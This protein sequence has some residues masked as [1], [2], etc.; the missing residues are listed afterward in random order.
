MTSTSTPYLR[1]ATHPAGPDHRGGHRK[2]RFVIGAALVAV[3]ALVAA[4]V[5]AF[6]SVF[7]VRTVD[8]NGAAG[9]SVASIR[10]AAHVS[11]G[12]PLVRLDTAAIAA[13]VEK[14]PAIA[15]AKVSTSFPSTVTIT[16]TERTPVGYTREGE[17]VVLIDRDG[18][19]YRSVSGVPPH[20]PHFVLPAGAGGRETG[21]ALA[22]V[23]AALPAS[24][25]AEVVTVQAPDPTAITLSVQGGIEVRWGD[26]THSAEKAR[27]VR[28]LMA[29]HPSLID[30][31]DPA[32]PFTR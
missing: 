15:S 31:T 27:I 23:A 29:K 7:G 11:Q 6:S 30:V 4:W 8:V 18:V 32:Q 13:R 3:I 14:I 26:S 21:A 9:V 16:V 22:V 10:E 1:S 24:L 19:Q 2:R 17:R 28:T 20:L 5:V 12:S 25:R